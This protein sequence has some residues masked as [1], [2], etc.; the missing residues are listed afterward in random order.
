VPREIEGHAQ[1]LPR[2]PGAV[3]LREFAT[4]GSNHVGGRKH[5]PWLWLPFCGDD[6]AQFHANCRRVG[7]D[8]RKQKN[9]LSAQIQ[10]FKAQLVGMWMVL[11]SMEK[12]VNGKR[13]K[14]SHHGG[15]T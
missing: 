1:A 2:L 10:A 3:L 7:V 15:K 13:G 4:T 14:R 12:Q 11:E 5:V 9:K 6:H 8:F